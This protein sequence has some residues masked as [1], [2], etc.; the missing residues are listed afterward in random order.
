[1]TARKVHTTGTVGHAARQGKYYFIHRASR[2]VR[3]DDFH[4][5]PIPINEGWEQV[6]LE[7]W[8]AFRKE[9]KKLNIKVQKEL[10]R[11]YKCY[12]TTPSPSLKSLSVKETSTKPS[13]KKSSPKRGPSSNKGSEPSKPA[14]SKNSLNKGSKPKAK[15]D[16]SLKPSS[17][18]PPAKPNSP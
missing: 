3:V 16:A 17:T 4:T 9:T 2:L 8:E 18:K 6:S 10:H 5:L 12:S 11:S 13:E 1:M 15:S 14:S 7:R